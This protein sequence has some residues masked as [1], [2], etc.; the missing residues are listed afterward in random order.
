VR[1]AP[2][3]RVARVP[4]GYIPCSVL[5]TPVR[6]TIG[7]AGVLSAL[8]TRVDEAERFKVRPGGDG[9][10]DVV[11][12]LRQ[13]NLEVDLVAV[14]DDNGVGLGLVERELEVPCLVLVAAPS[15]AAVG[16]AVTVRAVGH[17]VLAVPPK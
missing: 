9:D 4:A 3:A 10:T 17:P 11:E 7:S 16:A 1:L 15:A 2:D 14:V 5:T 12:R 6:S 13:E 8:R